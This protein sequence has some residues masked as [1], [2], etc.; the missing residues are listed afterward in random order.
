MEGTSL[1]LVLLYVGIVLLNNGIC[2]FSKIDDRSTAIMNWIVGG[3]SLFVNGVAITQ[4][5]YYAAAT[6]LLFG[7]TYILNAVTKRFGI[8]PR[9]YGWFSLFVVVNCFPA[10]AVDYMA[11]DVNMA[12]IWI[13]W[14]ILWF[15]GWYET[16]LN[17]SLGKFVPALLVFEGIVTAWVPGMLM[18]TGNWSGF[19]FN[20]MI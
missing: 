4:G 1:G 19:L 15:T 3:L 6:G 20:G 14:A 2:G 13:L 8:D 10:A 7:F 17:K 18:L 5:H 16:V 9:I 12:I 11:G